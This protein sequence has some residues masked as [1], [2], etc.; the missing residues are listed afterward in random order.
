MFKMRRGFSVFACSM[1]LCLGMVSGVSAQAKKQ[2]VFGF[3]QP[4]TEE[5]FTRNYAGFK[6][7]CDQNGIKVVYKQPMKNGDNTELVNLVDE[8]IARGVDAIGTTP[9]DSRAQVVSA[10]SARKAQIPFGT[11]GGTLDI[12]KFSLNDVD[13]KIIGDNYGPAK[14]LGLYIAKLLGG[15]GNIV[16]LFGVPGLS[17]SEDRDRGIRDGIKEGGLTLLADQPCNYNAQTA[18]NVMSDFLTKYPKIDAVF[19]G[20][21]DGV[22]AC[23]QA[24]KAVHREKEMLFFGF[25]GTKGTREAIAK[26]E[27]TGTIDM[28]SY[29][30]GWLLAMGLH[31]KALDPNAQRMSVEVE[32]SILTHEN[33]LKK[34][35]E[36]KSIYKP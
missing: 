35:P 23:Y 30:M 6:S 25:D 1:L 26:K 32:F 12:P 33:I 21:D 9:N 5:W 15:K 16:V 13:V 22:L 19:G 28:N 14:S 20:Y 2:L 10:E 36:V 27:I 29:N 18:Y 4:E 7:Y 11:N 24:A 31:H 3:V 8:L 17:N 34:Y